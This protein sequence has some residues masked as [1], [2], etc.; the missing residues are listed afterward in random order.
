MSVA[1]V[2]SYPEL[3]G[4]QQAR[5]GLLPD[6]HPA[7]T[8]PR[9]QLAGRIQH[10][11]VG[12]GI[13]ERAVRLH[14]QETL[15]HGFDAAVVPAAW[16]AVAR[17]ELRGT[18]A[19]IGSIVDYPHGSSTTAGRRA[20]AASLVDEGV[21]ELDATVNIGYLL[22]G[23]VTEFAADLKAVVDAAS[24]IGVKVMLELPLLDRRQREQAVQAAI[25]A[26]AAFVKPASRGAVGIADPATIAY[27]RRAVPA[28]IGV[29]ASGGV[30]TIE[31]VRALL[32]AGADL[33]GTSSG[34][35]IVTGGGLAKGSLYSY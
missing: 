33:I 12:Q 29:K 31:Q 6:E 21:D 14:I 24:P 30:K 4:V 5:R 22:S 19:R 34:V 16:V 26:G 17:D 13:T 20:E 25:D 32:A 7:L 35:S 11:L 15:T 8:L 18:S 9:E 3:S 23:R 1:P 2:G 28:S 27:L 10:T